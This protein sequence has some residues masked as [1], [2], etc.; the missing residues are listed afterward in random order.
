MG[1]LAL[2]TEG[3]RHFTKCRCVADRRCGRLP[4]PSEV[5]TTLRGDRRRPRGRPA[6]RAR[7]PRRDAPAGEPRGRSLRRSRQRGASDRRCAHERLPSPH[8]GAGPGRRP[9]RRSA[10]PPE[11]ARNPRHDELRAPTRLAP[12]ERPGPRF[13]RS[14]S[15]RCLPRGRSRTAAPSSSSTPRSTSSRPTCALPPPR[16]TRP[17]IPPTSSTAAS[18]ASSR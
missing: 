5:T 3:A 18:A 8:R 15:T 11:A 10:Q 12:R 13:A 6:E 7:A 1:A 2:L 16:A 4:L 9:Q 14:S 17:S